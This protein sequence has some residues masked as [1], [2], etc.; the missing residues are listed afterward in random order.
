MENCGPPLDS[1]YNQELWESDA[2]LWNSVSSAESIDPIIEARITR[3]L[4]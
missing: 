4:P 3:W 2:K 1:G